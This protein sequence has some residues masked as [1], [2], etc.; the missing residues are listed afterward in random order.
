MAEFA[1]DSEDLS[2]VE[3]ARLVLQRDPQTVEWVRFVPHPDV[4]TKSVP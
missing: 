2:D 1:L 3:L 4:P